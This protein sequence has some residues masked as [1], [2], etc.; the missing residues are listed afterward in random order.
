MS[1]QQWI[2]RWDNAF[3]GDRCPYYFAEYGWSEVQRGAR[4]FD[5]CEDADNVVKGLME[6]YKNTY[7]E[8]KPRVVRLKP[9]SKTVS[10]VKVAEIERFFRD[11]EWSSR[12]TGTLHAAQAYECCAGALRALLKEST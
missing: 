5:K 4:R 12:C 2:V 8:T 11:K 7:C 10:A 1:K 3:E 9:C 6:F